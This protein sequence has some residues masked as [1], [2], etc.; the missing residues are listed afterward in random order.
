MRQ[1][2]FSL[3]V[4]VIFL[5]VALAHA[6]RLTFGWHV[7]V[8]GWAVPVWVSWAAVVITLYLA[9]AGFR[10]AKKG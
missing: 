6:L 10:L 9:F 2:T 1:T 7:A 8:N 4:S 3:V 5:L